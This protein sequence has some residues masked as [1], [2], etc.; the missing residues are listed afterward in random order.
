[1]PGQ[2]TRIKPL[3]VLEKPKRVAAYARV[4]S[5]KDAISLTR[6]GFMQEYIQ[7]RPVPGRRKTGRVSNVFSQTVIMGGSI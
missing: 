7:T 2:V 6:V 3:P 1:M 4:S 5:E